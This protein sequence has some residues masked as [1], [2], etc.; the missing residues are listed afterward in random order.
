L[1]NAKAVFSVVFGLAALAVFVAAAVLAR[2]RTDI[3]LAEAGVAVCVGVLLAVV[4]LSLA[5]RARFKYQR[6]LG[7]V[8][9]S[10]IAAGGRLL[11]TVALL[12]GITAGLAFGVF[13]V[14]TIVLD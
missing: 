8:G 12:V 3:G 10:A 11:G 5:R 7:R 2:V 14:L 1:R 13:G 6:T 4:A 9:G